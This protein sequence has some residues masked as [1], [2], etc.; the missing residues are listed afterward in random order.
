MCLENERAKKRQGARLRNRGTFRIA[1]IPPPQQVEN[2]FKGKKEA[3]NAQ[4][5][6]T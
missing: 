1:Q 3:K 2:K 5:V 6:C 4:I